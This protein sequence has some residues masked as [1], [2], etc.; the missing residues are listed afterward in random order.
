MSLWSSGT[1]CASR[2]YEQWD[3]AKSKASKTV[4]WTYNQIKKSV[5]LWKAVQFPL[6][7]GTKTNVKI[8]TWRA[9]PKQCMYVS[10]TL[11][12]KGQQ[13]K[14]YILLCGWA[15]I[16]HRRRDTGS[17]E[18][19]T[20]MSWKHQIWF[21]VYGGRSV[22]VICL[23]MTFTITIFCIVKMQRVFMAHTSGQHLSK[24]TVVS[25][26]TYI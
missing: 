18:W 24:N 11:S 7:W 1:C 16:N 21:Q 17:S 14:T 3:Q 19:M 8:W 2:N 5:F 4:F 10:F 26:E 15:T 22:V 6:P 9:H 12:S 23:L 13:R 25:L 20:A